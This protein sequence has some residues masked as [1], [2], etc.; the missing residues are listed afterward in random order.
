M[1]LKTL[2][3]RLNF[4]KKIE[5]FKDL[6]YRTFVKIADN[7]IELEISENEF[8]FRKGDRGDSISRME[9]SGTAGR[10]NISGATYE[11]VKDFFHC[12][13]RGK[14]KAKNKGEMDMYYVNGI[15][16]DLSSDSSDN[17]FSSVPNE[18]FWKLH[19]EL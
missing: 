19:E 7:L 6:D 9:S 15:R 4:L 16:K 11:L 14:V 13:H 5:I 12:E 3:E 1:R 2:E 18:K 17:S 8:L 10:I